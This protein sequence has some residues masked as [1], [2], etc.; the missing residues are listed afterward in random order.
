MVKKICWRSIWASEQGWRRIYM[1]ERDSCWCQNI[2]Q[3]RIFMH[4]N[5]YNL[6][7]TVWKKGTDPASGNSVCENTLSIPEDNDHWFEPIEKKR[8]STVLTTKIC[9]RASPWSRWATTAEEHSRCTIHTDSPKTGQQKFGKNASYLTSCNFCSIPMVSSEF[10]MEAW[11]YLALY[12]RLV[13]VLVWGSF[14]FNTLVTQVPSEHNLNA[15][16]YL[17][18]AEVHPLMTTSYDGPSQQDNASGHKA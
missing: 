11:I 12:Q 14:C 4:N 3:T 6:Q 15:T 18:N 7:T 5:F 16:A 2:S 1:T 13:G 8:N 17:S 9:R 10:I